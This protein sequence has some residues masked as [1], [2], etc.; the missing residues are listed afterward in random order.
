VN[1]TEEELRQCAEE[2]D[3]RVALKTAVAKKRLE[4]YPNYQAPR[5]TRWWCAAK[6]SSYS[7]LMSF[8]CLVP[9]F[10]C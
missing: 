8:G 3:M 9:E 7:L 6:A 1:L 2:V 10:K 4:L 5:V